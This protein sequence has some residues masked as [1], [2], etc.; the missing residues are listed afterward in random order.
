MSDGGSVFGHLYDDLM[1]SEGLQAK[2]QEFLEARAAYFKYRNL[3][4]KHSNDISD[5][6]YRGES[7]GDLSMHTMEFLSLGLMKYDDVPEL[8]KYVIK[9][10]ETL[11]AWKSLEQSL[12]LGNDKLSSYFELIPVDEL[13]DIISDGN[14]EYEKV[15]RG[16]MRASGGESS[17]V[18]GES[19]DGLDD[20][21]DDMIS[22]GNLMWEDV[23]RASRRGRGVG[24]SKESGRGVGES[25]KSGRGN[26]VG[27]SRNFNQPA[28]T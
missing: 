13:D 20:W 17:G 9:Y 27:L 21:L 11:S 4:S 14:R 16:L 23:M 19:K 2:T 7:W 15:L 6:Y 25:K 26:L 12:E 5:A 1:S 22:D 3:L 28:Y 24:E 10:N 8:R 18:G